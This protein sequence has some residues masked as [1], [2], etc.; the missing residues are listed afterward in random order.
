MYTLFWGVADLQHLS[1]LVKTAFIRNW[2]LSLLDFLTHE[3][4][5][6]RSA[7]RRSSTYTSNTY[8][9][10]KSRRPPCPTAAARPF[11]GVLG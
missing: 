1:A 8:K 11:L 4:R 9:T 2:K 7:T 5:A 3:W 10:L 6:I